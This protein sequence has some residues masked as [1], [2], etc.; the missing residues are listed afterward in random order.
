VHIPPEPEELGWREAFW[1]FFAL[2]YVTFRIR[3]DIRN[4]IGTEDVSQA[5]SDLEHAP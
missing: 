4:G 1:R 2:A 5:P 3:R